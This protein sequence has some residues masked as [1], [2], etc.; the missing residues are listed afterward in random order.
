MQRSSNS[1]NL[2]IAQK[3]SIIHT[4]TTSLHLESLW[5]NQMNTYLK[6]LIHT[7]H[8]FTSFLIHPYNVFKTNEAKGIQCKFKTITKYS[9][10]IPNLVFYSFSFHFQRNIQLFIHFTNPYVRQS[11]KMKYTKQRNKKKREQRR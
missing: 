1:Q 6:S 11:T 2:H 9:C 4:F 8:S 3:I 10:A 5:L 7:P